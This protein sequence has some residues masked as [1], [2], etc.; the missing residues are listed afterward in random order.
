[1]TIINSTGTAN[2]QLFIITAVH[3][4]RGRWFMWHL[5]AEKLNT[6][7]RR[8]WDHYVNK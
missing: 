1:M 6:P 4:L 2:I 8:T 3:V 7:R 5:Y